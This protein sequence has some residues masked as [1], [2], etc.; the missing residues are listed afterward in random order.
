MSS[1]LPAPEPPDL[2]EGALGHFDHSNW[3]KAALKALDQGT[4]HSGGGQVSGQLTVEQLTVDDPGSDDSFL[5]LSGARTRGLQGKNAAG[6]L[7]WRL[8]L[9]DATAESGASSGS[10]F[11]LLSY[12]DTGAQMHQVLKADRA[13]GLVE[14]KGSPTAAK[15]VATKEY[16]DDSVPIG[17]IAPYGGSV[18]PAGWHMCNGTAHGSAALEAIIGSPNTPDLSGKFIVGT[19]TGY[20]PG[21]TGGVASV[22]L[23]PAQTA[24]K[25]HGH[26]GAANAVDINHTHQINP[27]LTWSSDINQNHQHNVIVGG[28]D[29]NHPSS[30]ASQNLINIDAAGSGFDVLSRTADWISGGGH[31]HSG[32]SDPA[33]QGHAHSVD[34][35]QFG[36][37]WMD[38]NNPHSHTVT[39]NPTVDANAAAPIDNRPPY[40]ALIYI[41]K[42]V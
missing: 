12:S 4:V 20:T 26:T 9:G 41:I 13:S 31:A 7:R 32:W 35:G 6:I 27:P 16:V 29:H 30:Y 10:L 8:I 21:S 15:G 40:Y 36:S 22:T 17:L 24:T 33:N 19:G 38:Q 25:G 42:K 11:S 14:V 34:I 5:S 37:G 3:V 23:T 28:G 39:V 2:V 18:A 1:L